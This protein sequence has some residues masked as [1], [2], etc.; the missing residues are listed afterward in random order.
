MEP[1]YLGKRSCEAG[2]KFESRDAKLGLYHKA[3]GMKYVGYV[4][5]LSAT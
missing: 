1:W 2:R 4:G 5:W 3:R